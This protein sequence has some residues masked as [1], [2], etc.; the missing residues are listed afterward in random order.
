MPIKPALSPSKAHPSA[1]QRGCFLALNMVVFALCYGLSNRYGAQLAEHGDV[2]TIW[3]QQIL[4]LPWMLVP[5]MSSGPFF[6]ACF[7]WPRELPALRALSLRLLFCTVLASLVFVLW[8]LK[9]QPRPALAPGLFASLF[10]LLGQIDQPY[11]QLPSLHVAYCV[12]IAASLRQRFHIFWRVV[13]GAWLLLTALSTLFTYQHHLWDVF[14]GAAL[15]FISV[16]LIRPKPLGAPYMPP[17]AWHYGLASVVALTLAIALHMPR[18]GGYLALSFAL[19]SLAY[20]RNQHS[21]LGKHQGR[22]PLYSGVLFAPYLLG[23]WLC[24]QL[25][26][27]RERNQPVLRQVADRLWVSRRLTQSESLQLPEP[28]AVIDLANELSEL[29]KFRGAHYY[30]F[31][32]LDLT[33]IDAAT[34]A[35]IL[36]CIDT[37]LQAGRNVLLHCAMGYQRSHYLSQLWLCAKCE[38]DN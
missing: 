10:T 13:L 6:V 17:V 9:V 4:F 24:W 38:G 36:A 15:G 31:P 3:D 29:P 16:M 2:A 11:N 1:A 35:R 37:Q 23:Y 19:I 20:A 7:F 33:T 26:R 28:F 30:F 25:V 8:P 21:F 14:A 27:W 12:V 32:M 34:A 5:Y 18:L 22:F